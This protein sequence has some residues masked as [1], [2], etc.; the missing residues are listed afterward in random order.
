MSLGNLPDYWATS[1]VLGRLPDSLAIFHMSLGNLPHI[2]LATSH[3]CGRLQVA[4]QSP[5]SFENLHIFGSLNCSD[6]KISSQIKLHIALFI[7][8]VDVLCDCLQPLLLILS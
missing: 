2:F 5:M 8:S 1:H 4:W 7:I 3:L 6:Y